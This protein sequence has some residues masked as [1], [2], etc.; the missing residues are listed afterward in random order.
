M[1]DA[2]RASGFLRGLSLQLQDVGARG[3][4]ETPA[5]LGSSVL[6]P[7]GAE[8]APSGLQDSRRLDVMGRTWRLD[9]SPGR[10]L[11]SST[12]RMMPWWVGGAGLVLT[13]LLAALAGLFA[14]Q[15]ARAF[16]EVAST[17]EALRR[18][19]VRFRAIFNQ[20]PVAVCL[21][22][23]KTG[24]LVRVNQK[25]CDI[26]GYARDDLPQ[27]D[28]RQQTHPAD[29]PGDF[30]DA[31]RHHLREVLPP[32]GALDLD[33]GVVVRRRGEGAQGDPAGPLVRCRHGPALRPPYWL[34]GGVTLFMRA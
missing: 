5:V 8:P 25:Y 10:A 29:L 16:T 22:D 15:R 27:L 32:G 13:L 21:T 14:R 31:R 6:P 9:F 23:A 4:P 7:D 26:L 11:L 2:I 1:L 18:S 24:R 19:Q 20:A 33:A 28:F 30:Q 12:E 3:I 17:H 34:Q